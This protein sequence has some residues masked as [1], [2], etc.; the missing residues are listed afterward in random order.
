MFTD[1]DSLCYKIKTDDVYKSLFQDKELLDDSNYPK[2]SEFFSDEN[3]KLIGKVNDEAAGMV[4][5][6]Y[7]GLRTK[8]YSYEFYN[9]TTRNVVEYLNTP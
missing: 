8:I 1:T 7:I 2:N 3:K 4:I 5:I 6:E 9:K